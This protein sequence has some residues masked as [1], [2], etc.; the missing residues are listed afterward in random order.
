MCYMLQ[1]LKPLKN[2]ENGQW[3]CEFKQIGGF[4]NVGNGKRK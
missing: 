2:F 1:I 4:I 3:K